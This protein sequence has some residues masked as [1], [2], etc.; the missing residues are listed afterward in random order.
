MIITGPAPI[1][2]TLKYYLQDRRMKMQEFPENENPDS[3]LEEYRKQLNELRREFS[4]RDLPDVPFFQ[5][6]MGNRKKLMYKNG[7]LFDPFSGELYYKWSVNCETIIPNEYRVDILTSEGMQV[8]IF[9]NETGV[10][11]LEGKKSRKIGNTD[12]PLN[13]PAFKAYKYSEVLKVLHH[14]ILINILD[15]KPLP[16]YLVYSNPWRRDAAMM[17]MC[18]DSTGNLQ[19]I[20]NWVM[21]MDDPY[22]RNN[23]GETEADNLGQTLYLVSLFSDTTH[24]VVQKI[25]K[26]IPRYEIKTGHD[27]FIKGRSDFH[28][29]PVYQTKW[30]KY[31]LRSLGIP[32]KYTIPQLQ[33]NYS[34]LFWWAYKESYM[35]GTL[36]AYEEWG[37]DKDLYPEYPYIGWAADHFHGKRRNAISNRDY[38]LTWE[39]DAGQADYT[40]MKTLD[41]IYVNQKISTPHTWHASEV[42]LYLLEFK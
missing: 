21:H 7:K 30:L 34:S 18:L 14:E 23:A 8:S 38:P 41:D 15:S 11:I 4:V 1:M 24:P 25:I 29:A 26:E 3:C 32:D 12:V 16:N 37:M 28:D 39:Q 42:F 36:D 40:G 22:D 10:Y 9:E 2:P 27:I 13:L 17:A 6:G 33:D 20:K 5:F 35:P 19:L 31:G